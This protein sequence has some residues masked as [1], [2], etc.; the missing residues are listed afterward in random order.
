ML[1][2]KLTFFEKKRFGMVF[3]EPYS[4]L[5]SVK[6]DIFFQQS[7]GKLFG[8][9]IHNSKFT[10]FNRLWA[11]FIEIPANV[12][13]QHVGWLC[14]DGNQ[15]EPWMHCNYGYLL[16]AHKKNTHPVFIHVYIIYVLLTVHTNCVYIYAM[17]TLYHV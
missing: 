15:F 6:L 9:D 4:D 3:S 7:I 2:I 16:L 17:F 11:R 12:R 1:Y 10:F 14:S 8:I 5:I 13:K